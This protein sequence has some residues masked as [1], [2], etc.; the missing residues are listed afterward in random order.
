MVRSRWTLIL[1][2]SLAAYY[3]AAAPDFAAILACSSRSIASRAPAPAC[4]GGA[5]GAARARRARTPRASGVCG[6]CGAGVSGSVDTD[7]LSHISTTFVD[8]LHF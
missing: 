2:E 5:G 3:V 7:R 4:R 1:V 6:S 8:L